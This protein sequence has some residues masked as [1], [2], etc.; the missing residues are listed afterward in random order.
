MRNLSL[1]RFAPQG[2][3]SYS[4]SQGQ[5][6][7]IILLIMAVA[8]TI[9]LSV[10]SRSITDIR[11]SQQTEEAAR[12]YS[13]AEAGIEEALAR[14]IIGSFEAPS[15]FSTTGATYKTAVAGVGEGATEYVFPQKVG[16]NEIQTLWLAKNDDLSKVYDRDQLRLVWG[17]KG[18]ALSEAP[19]LEV[20]IYYRDGSD[21]KAGRFALDPYSA[22][23]PDPSFCN[24]GEGSPQCDGVTNF[25]TTGERGADTDFQFGVTLDIGAFRG[26][27]KTLLFAR[28]RFLFVGGEHLLGAKTQGGGTGN[29]PSQGTKIESSGRA[30]EATRKVEV[31]R[32][33]PAP[34]EIFDFVLYSGGTLVK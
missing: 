8:L 4:Y 1:R 20:I 30:G 24:P 27:N 32:L 34:P 2:K 22:R 33:H 11:I 15:D 7:L 25:V 17:N 19:A 3:L 16:R 13:A 5:A 10:I 26:V 28:L 18:T 12:A 6:L 23:T 21:Y 29:F 14:G 31:V 9:G